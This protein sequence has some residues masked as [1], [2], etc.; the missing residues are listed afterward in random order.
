MI[1]FEIKYLRQK[2]QF[3]QITREVQDYSVFFQPTQGRIDWK[4]SQ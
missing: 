2:L 1:T 3:C 4:V